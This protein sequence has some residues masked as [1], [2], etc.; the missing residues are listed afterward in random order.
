MLIITLTY[1]SFSNEHDLLKSLANF[2]RRLDPDMIIGWAFLQR[3][4]I[5]QIAQRMKVDSKSG[6]LSPYKRHRYEYMDWDQPI[7]GVA[8]LDL[9]TGS[10]KLWVLQER[11]DWTQRSSTM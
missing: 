10:E 1:F 8:C 6:D 11:T 7:P 2:L 4:D 9:K 5:K 3:A